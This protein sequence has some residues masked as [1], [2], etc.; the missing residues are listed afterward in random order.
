MTDAE[1]NERFDRLERAMESLI[2]SLRVELNLIRGAIEGG[3][4]IPMLTSEPP[5]LEVDAGR[6]E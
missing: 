6:K 3:A 5:I 1:L 4:A 2:R